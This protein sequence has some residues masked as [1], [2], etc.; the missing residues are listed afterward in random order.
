MSFLKILLK[1]WWYKLSY[2]IFTWI[3]MD[4]FWILDPD[5]HK[6]L[7]GSE[8]LSGSKLN[9]YWKSCESRSLFRI[10]YVRSY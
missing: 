9:P 2:L 8:T 7:C 4:I 5:P 10:L 1:I 6:N 3:H